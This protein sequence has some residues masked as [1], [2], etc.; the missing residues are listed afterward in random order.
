MPSRSSIQPRGDR[1]ISMEQDGKTYSGSYKV[2]SGVL[3]LWVD[4]P[5]G[6]KVGPITQVLRG[7]PPEGAAESLLR[8]YARTKR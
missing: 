5:E 2:G 7:G 1:R 4:G 6:T 3:S 8:E